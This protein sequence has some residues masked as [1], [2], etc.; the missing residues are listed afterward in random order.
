[1]MC[2]AVLPE[3]TDCLEKNMEKAPT[4]ET[5]EAMEILVEGV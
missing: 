3:R 1:M 4:K 2:S 5:D